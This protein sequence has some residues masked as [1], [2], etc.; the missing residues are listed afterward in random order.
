M[1]ADREKNDVATRKGD[2]A[3]GTHALREALGE[4][5]WASLMRTPEKL[6][7]IAEV[8]S[9]REDFA[10]IAEGLREIGLDPLVC[11][12]LLDATRDGAFSHFGGAAHISA[13]AARAIIP[14]LRE[15]L[16]YSEACARV[17]YDHAARPAVALKEINSPVARKRVRRSDQANA[18]DPCARI[19]ADRLSPRRTGARRRQER[20]GTRKA[21]RRHR[22]A[23]QGEGQARRKRR[24]ISA[25]RV[26]DDEL[27]RYELCKEQNFKCV[28]CGDPIAPDGFSANDTR[29][30]VDHILPWSRFGD[31]SYR[32]K[33]LCC[34]ACNQHKRGR[35]PFEWFDADKT[36]E[37][38]GSFVAR[39]EGFKEMKGLKKRNYK[40]KDAAS[41]EEK[42]KARN[43]TDTQWATR[44]LADELKR[45]FP[46]RKANE[47]RVFT[48]PG[49]ITSKLRRAWGLEGLKKVDGERV[50]TTATMRST[51]SYWQRRP[52]ACCNDDQGGAAARDAKGAADD[53]FHVAPAVAR[54][55]RW[56]ATRAIYGE[57]GVGGIFVS[58]AERPRA[59]GKAHDATIRQIREIDGEEIV[60]ERKAI[61]KLTESRPREDSGA[62]ALRRRSSIPRNCATTTVAALRAWIAAGKPKGED[63]LPRSP[64]GDI[65][66][67]VR[68]ES[69]NKVGSA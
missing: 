12:R 3:A 38:M 22:G 7:R 42:F 29:Y 15:G 6:D 4:A 9:F 47:R 67:K 41:V 43:L 35:T 30:Q 51:L 62:R 61:E 16:V 37:R 21:E 69:K 14:G 33:T 23:Q 66:R 19:R 11:E 46:H 32:N 52:K 45:M 50:P 39:V 10:R 53:I 31:N 48:R 24:N 59:R 55:S 20:G 64:K 60:F 28:Y 27:L 63:K 8:L 26:S 40:L 1:P 34:D 57:N 36:P 2:A 5:P 68:V 18:R 49:A 65:I 25:P 56:I 44:L 54:L 13:K 58:R 17:G